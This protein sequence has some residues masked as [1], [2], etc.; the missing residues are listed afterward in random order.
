MDKI[1]LTKNQL[2]LIGAAAAILL[3]MIIFGGAARGCV[4]RGGVVIIPGGIDAGPGERVIA[5]QLDA[6]IRFGEARM[7]A[8]EAK[9]DDDLA[10]FDARQR[11]EY[12]R[13]RGGDDLEAAAQML[14]EWN[15]SR[16]DAGR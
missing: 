15:R 11:A 5:A 13:L 7:V 3:L 9:F 10:A 14:S 2:I 12:E 6:D 16:R 8:I 4:E 1:T